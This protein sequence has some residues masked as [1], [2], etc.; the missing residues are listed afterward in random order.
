MNADPFVMLVKVVLNLY[1]FIVLLRLVL[2]FTRADF[3]NPISQGVVKATSPFIL[4]LRKVIPAIGRIDTASLVLA[5]AVQLLTVF[6]IVLMKGA[7]LSAT[8]YAIY[9]VAGTLYHLLDLYFWAMLISI[10]LSWVAPGASHP[11][12]MLVGQ[13]TEP[14]YRACQR[15]IPPLGGLDLSPIFIFLAI[16]FLKQILGPYSI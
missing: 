1:L 4:P 8:G 16:S 2:Q 11:G 12:A 7:T 15:V 3:Y 9:T 10:I 5:L 6:A 14:L 13:I